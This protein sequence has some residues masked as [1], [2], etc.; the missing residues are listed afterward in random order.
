MS[1]TILIADDDPDV[2]ELFRL[3]LTR[4]GFTA[5]TASNGVDAIRIARSLLPDVIVLD[6]MM[7]QLD[8]LTVCETLRNQTATSQIPIL[9]LTGLAGELGRAAGLGGGADDYLIKPVM[10]DQLISRIEVLLRAG[11]RRENKSAGAKERK[12]APSRR[13]HLRRN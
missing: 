7:P 9:L 3:S 10:P 5:V 4:A 12:T 8:G 2:R 1:K 11:E 13:A 6:L